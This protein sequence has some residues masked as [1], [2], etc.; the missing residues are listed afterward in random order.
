MPRIQVQCSFLGMVLKMSSFDHLRQRSDWAFVTIHEKTTRSLGISLRITGT[1]SPTTVML[2][3]RGRGVIECS[4]PPRD[5]LQGLPANKPPLHGCSSIR[6][7]GV[8]GDDSRRWA[9]AECS[10]QID[11]LVGLWAIGNLIRLCSLHYL[12]KHISTFLD[13]IHKP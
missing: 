11:P 2:R 6:F 10:S 8:A 9:C 3:S 12:V 5:E 13:S 1:S 4:F 7:G